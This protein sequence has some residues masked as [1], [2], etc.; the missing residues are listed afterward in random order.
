MFHLADNSGDNRKGFNIFSKMAASDA[1]LSGIQAGGLFYSNFA[2]V[3]QDGNAYKK[4][5]KRLRGYLLQI[6]Y[7]RQ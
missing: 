1:R 7:Y 2:L 6:K 4:A 3:P 5:T